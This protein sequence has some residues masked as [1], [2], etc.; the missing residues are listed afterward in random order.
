[1][2]AADN[3]V[4]AYDMNMGFPDSVAPTSPID[5]VEE[6]DFD[7]LESSKSKGKHP[8]IVITG[9]TGVPFGKNLKRRRTSKHYRDDDTLHA[10][11]GS[12]KRKRGI[13]DEENIFIRAVKK[14]SPAARAS[15]DLDE[16]D[17]DQ[18][19]HEDQEVTRSPP[20]ARDIAPGLRN[21][22]L[23]DLIQ[24]L[25]AD[26]LK[27]GG[28]PDHAVAEATDNGEQ[29]EVAIRQGNGLIHTKYITWDVDPAVPDTLLIDERDFHKCLSNIFS[30]AVKFTE[31]GSVTLNVKLGTSLHARY[32]IINVADSGPGIPEEFRPHLFKP[33]SRED[34]STTRTTEGLGLGLL[35]ARSLAR[36]K[37]HGDVI[38][39]RSNTGGE[40]HGSEFEMRVPLTP[41]DA[42]SRPATPVGSPSPHTVPRH[43]SVGS[44]AM[45][46]V[47]RSIDRRPSRS[48]YPTGN[49]APTSEPREIPRAAMDDEDRHI[50]APKPTTSTPTAL[51]QA[52]ESQTRD[53]TDSVAR[54]SSTRPRTST[55]SKGQD[56]DRELAKKHP[57]NIL[58]AED[59]K[60]N[61]KLLVSMLSKL[62]YTPHEAYDGQDAVR[63]VESLL[64]SSGKE[65]A[66]IDP[67]GKQNAA[68]G[69]VDLVL[70]D[71]WMPYMDG[72]E[73][74][75]KIMHMSAESC[76]RP[77]VLA[78]SA[79]V[80]EQTIERVHKAGMKGFMA[81]P[82]QIK[83]VQNLI[84]QYAAKKNDWE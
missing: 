16:S 50:I 51:A 36:L 77:V 32:I 13:E 84:L 34:A 83:D 18:T 45:A 20:M 3:V 78:V 63:Q 65:N 28:R 10:P 15:H 75:E 47:A 14:L 72:Y 41:S 69:L 66:K 29:I 31:E 71:L 6:A 52:F 43:R 11:N 53:R 68:K 7:L 8:D 19:S 35:V 46:E 80:T 38:C 37:L 70:M 42:V 56:F 81:K 76:K 27:V 1:M 26:S 40:N 33:F 25:V 59:N 74:T 2:E 57:L 12:V 21:C 73:A 17:L 58:V 44:P 60:I 4:H 79:D 49:S 54:R 62:G 61:R 24:G 39:L 22:N 5:E 30:N 55:T 48:P 64:R 23:R 82:F 67:S 9:G